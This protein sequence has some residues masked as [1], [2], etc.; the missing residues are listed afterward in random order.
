VFDEGSIQYELPTTKQLKETAAIELA[1]LA[2]EH[3]QAENPA[4]YPLL[5]SM[6]LHTAMHELWNL[7]AP[8]KELS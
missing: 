8:M 7:R 2:T 4:E 3:R 6:P 5:L 1:K